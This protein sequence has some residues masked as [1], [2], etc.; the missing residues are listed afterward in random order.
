MSH[1]LPQRLFNPPRREREER[2]RNSVARLVNGGDH[3]LPADVGS[4][5]Y[6]PANLFHR[7]LP[8]RDVR[9]KVPG[10]VHAS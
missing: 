8:H 10:A 1:S 7:L 6:P 4:A 5:E 9:F 3:A 2:S